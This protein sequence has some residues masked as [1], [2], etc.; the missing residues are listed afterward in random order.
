ARAGVDRLNVLKTGSAPSSDGPKSGTMTSLLSVLRISAVRTC[1]VSGGSQFVT[2]KG[3]GL[4]NLYSGPR[5][6]LRPASSSLPWLLPAGPL[7][8]SKLPPLGRMLLIQLPQ[9]TP[10]SLKEA[11]TNLV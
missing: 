3:A 9:L 1:G 8:K 10:S 11:P 4:M 2:S 7:R 6:D 5:T